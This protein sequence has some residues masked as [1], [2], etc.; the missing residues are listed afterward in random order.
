[1]NAEGRVRIDIAGFSRRRL[2]LYAGVFGSIPLVGGCAALPPP[3]PPLRTFRLSPKTTFPENLPRVSWSLAIA[4]P[5]AER[6]LDTDRIA[7]LKEGTE[8][9]Y[10]AG[11][12]WSDRIPSLLQLLMVQ[13][14]LAS[15]AIAAVATDRDPLRPDFLLRS[16]LQ[17]FYVLEDAKGRRTAHVSITA[18]LLQMPMRQVVAY[19]AF[20]ADREIPSRSL[21]RIAR[22]FDEALGKVLKRLVLWTLREG[23]A[24]FR[25]AG[26]EE[27]VRGPA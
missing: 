24:R 27:R 10:L 23:E 19:Q 16:I 14:F 13:S 9:R 6:S 1:M 21:E 22:S 20:T 8:I 4:E 25:R 7:F 2:L 5:F 26:T 18:T 11:G 15:G 3:G 17:G 12:R